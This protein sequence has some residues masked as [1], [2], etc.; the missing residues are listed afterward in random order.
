M[1]KVR[2]PGK[3]VSNKASEKATFLSIYMYIHLNWTGMKKVK[4][5][6][7]GNM[8]NM[9]GIPVR[10]PLPTDGV[11]Q[12]D[13]FLL[14]HHGR[15]DVK[16]GADI[17]DTGVGPHP[18]RG[19]SPVTFVFSGGVHHRDSRGNSGEVNAGGVQW[20]NAGMGIIHSERP[21]KELIEKGGIQE[22][23][24]LWVNTPALRKMDQPYYLAVQKSDMP[25]MKPD[26][27]NGY[28]Q[29]VS[30]EQRGNKGAVEA[31]L[32]LLSM[33]G[34]LE[35]GARHEFTVMEGNHTILYLLDGRIKVNG[36]GPVDHHNL[37]EFE[38]AGASLEIAAE[39]N[40]RFL[41]LSAPPIKEPL[42]T[43]GPF[44]MNNQTQIMEAMRD[45]QMGKMG[46]LVEEFE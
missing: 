36:Y 2:S 8:V 38:P 4:Q 22:I 35:K 46:I 16:A 32:P 28:I 15:F 7:Y 34:E 11:R 42:A 33:M 26:Q 41:L 37:V 3:L 21:G 30:G 29:L 18:H 5:V 13:P 45:Y 20:M 19:F 9:G 31:P 12:I 1:K 14:L 40:T 27:G 44:V 24:Q 10:Q 17:K 6:L 23:I 39:Q 25:H 43:Y